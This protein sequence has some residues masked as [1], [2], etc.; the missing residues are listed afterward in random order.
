MWM[1]LRLNRSVELSVVRPREKG[2]CGI[3]EWCVVAR[4]EKRVQTM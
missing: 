2:M 4:A 3:H 1:L